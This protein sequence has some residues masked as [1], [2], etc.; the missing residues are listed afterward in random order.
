MSHIQIA[1]D[2]SYAKSYSIQVSTNN[3]TWTTIYSTTSGSGGT[4]D[5]AGLLL[6]ARYVRV[7]LMT[8]NAASYQ[9]N[10]ITIRGE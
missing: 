6:T 10:E 1:W 5:V 3:S 9:I 2:S 7:S 8:S 4:V